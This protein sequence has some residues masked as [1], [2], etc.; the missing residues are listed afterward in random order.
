MVYYEATMKLS[1]VVDF[2]EDVVVSNGMPSG[3]PSIGISGRMVGNGWELRGCKSFSSSLSLSSINL[4]DRLETL[5]F[6]TLLGKSVSKD[7]RY[8]Q[9]ISRTL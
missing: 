3:S 2:D 4:R 6:H 1:L 8:A 5:G 7:M 9:H